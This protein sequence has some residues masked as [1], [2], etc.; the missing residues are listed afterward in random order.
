MNRKSTNF[1]AYPIIG[2]D[3]NIWGV[4]II[5]NNEKKTYDF[6]PVKEVIKSYTDIISLTLEI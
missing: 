2:K 1:Y 4:L 5:D 6:A 3:A